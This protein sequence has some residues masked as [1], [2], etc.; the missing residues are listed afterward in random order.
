MRTDVVLRSA[1][2]TIVLD[3]KFYPRA[4]VT[5]LTGS[6]PK[7]HSSH[8]YQMLADLKNYEPEVG[9]AAG[10]LMIKQDPVA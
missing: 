10:G 3:T 5:S 8:L 7:V 4:L 9:A 1:E 6:Q 2:E